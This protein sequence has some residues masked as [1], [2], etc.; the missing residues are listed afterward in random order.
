MKVIVYSKL[1]VV[2]HWVSAVVILW[3]LL[4]GFYVSMVEV[5]PLTKC[6]VGFV[7]VSLT[8]MFIPVFVWRIYLAATKPKYRLP[9]NRTLMERLAHLMHLSI[10]LM[11]SL[12]LLTG[13]LMMD[14]AINIFDLVLMP[15]P[16]DDPLW[17]DRF[18]TLHVWSCVALLVQVTLHIAAV[19]K[20]EIC[21]RRILKKMAF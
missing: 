21:G 1:Q 8:A 14:R 18:F 19:I 16:L 3:A 5:T 13:I 12:V 7:N 4:S 11:T 2:L 10:Y 9:V 20:H 17:I 6:L 15:A